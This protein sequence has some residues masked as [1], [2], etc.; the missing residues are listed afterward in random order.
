MVSYT[1]SGCLVTDVWCVVLVCTNLSLLH[2]MANTHTS[3]MK[4]VERCPHYSELLTH[5][6]ILEY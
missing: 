1:L 6:L 3:L 4:D 2:V 5:P